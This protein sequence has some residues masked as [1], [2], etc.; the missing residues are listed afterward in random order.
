[1]DFKEKRNL[2]REIN[3]N[4]I[5]HIDINV[6]TSCNLGCQYCSEGKNLEPFTPERIKDTQT[7]VKEEELYSFIEKIYNQ[8]KSNLLISFWGGEPF[9]NFDFCYNVMKHYI[10]D[11]RLSFFFYTNGIYIKKYINKLKEIDEL[12]P[13]HLHVQISYDGG[14]V[15]DIER[16]TKQGKSTSKAVK[17]GY[18]ILRDNCISVDMKSTVSPRTFKYM[19]DAF[20]DI[21]SLP[22]MEDYFPTPD[23]FSMYDEKKWVE[24]YSDL[25]H[26]IS[27]I[28]KYIYD[29]NL[30]PGSFRWFEKSKAL[31]S[32]GIKYV[33]I[34]TF[35]NVTP[36]HSCMYDKQSEHKIGTI[37]ESNIIEKI[38]K[39]EKRFSDLNQIKREDQVCSKCTAPF[40]IRCPAGIYNLPYVKKQTKHLEGIERSNARWLSRNIDL[41]RVFRINEYIYNSLL[42]ALENRKS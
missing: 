17:E 32:A 34:D 22:D 12:H 41:C 1:M 11:D 16:V 39:A 3:S 38:I 5:F 2:F 31:C 25:K 29:N 36:C 35:G 19:F 37:Y 8:Y 28:A 6:C 13:G 15:N 23:A 42:K 33:T 40:C 26:N 30:P 7:N 4:N 10:N 18:N 20:K 21:I 9:L 14:K 24:Y 27:Q